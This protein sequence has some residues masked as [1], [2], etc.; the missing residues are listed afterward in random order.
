ML[1]G[2]TVVA[3]ALPVDMQLGGRVSLATSCDEAVW[4]V[5]G[6]PGCVGGHGPVP[7]RVRYSFY[8]AVLASTW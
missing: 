7:S 3:D 2:T 5:S 8:F 1:G 4:V 6:S